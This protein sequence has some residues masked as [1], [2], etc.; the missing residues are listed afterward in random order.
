METNGFNRK[1]L[2]NK[3]LDQERI[4]TSIAQVPG[5]AGRKK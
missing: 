1:Q 4:E 2:R 5:W 3:G